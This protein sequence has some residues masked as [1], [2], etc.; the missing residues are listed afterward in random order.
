LEVADQLISQGKA[1]EAAK[2]LEELRNMYGDNPPLIN[3]LKRAYLSTKSYDQVEKLF[4]FRPEERELH[5]H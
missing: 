1:T 3:L 5:R 2:L 4:S